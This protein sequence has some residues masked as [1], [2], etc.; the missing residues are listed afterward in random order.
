[1]CSPHP[2]CRKILRLP[3][4]SSR[5]LEILRK[6]QLSVGPWPARPAERCWRCDQPEAGAST[7]ALHL[8]WFSAPQRSNQIPF[9]HSEFARYSFPNRS[10]PP[11]PRTSL[12]LRRELGDLLSR[13]PEAPG[14]ASPAPAAR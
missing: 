4:T 10:R 3:P 9:L 14:R 13:R 6:T 12:R 8:P 5:R 7:L 2:Y 11:P 1:M